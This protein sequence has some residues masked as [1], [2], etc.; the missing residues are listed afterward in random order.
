MK[1]WKYPLEIT[2]VQTIRTKS[3]RAFLDVQVQRGQPCLWAQVDETGLTE[4][5]IIRIIGTGNPMPENPGF[6]IGTFQVYGGELVFHG[7]AELGN[8]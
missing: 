6:H 5:Y 2:D 7:F 1:I 4:E 8:G 3:V